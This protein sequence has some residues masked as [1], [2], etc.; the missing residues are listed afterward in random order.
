M[1]EIKYRAWDVFGKKMISWEE[2]CDDYEVCWGLFN[3]QHIKIPMQYTGL[4][5][6][7]DVDIYEGDIVKC[8]EILFRVLWSEKDAGFYLYKNTLFSLSNIFSP[9]TEVIGNIYEN[10]ELLEK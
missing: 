10:K 4:K 7:N 3:N 2:L 6:K 1:H 5:D 9:D 8:N